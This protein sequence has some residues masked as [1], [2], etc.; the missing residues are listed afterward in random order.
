MRHFLHVSTHGEP[1]GSL[2][3]EPREDRYDF[4]YADDWRARRCERV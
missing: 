4:S 2:G 1:V 3:F